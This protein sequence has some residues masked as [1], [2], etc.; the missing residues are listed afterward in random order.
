MPI[1]ASYAARI[2][3]GLKTPWVRTVLILWVAQVVSEIGFGFALPFTPLF[4]QE[5][6]VTDVKQAGLWAGFAAA[7]FAVAVGV[8]SPIWGTLA[9]RYGYRLMIQRAFFGAGAAL[10]AIYFVETPEQMIVLRILHGALTGVFTGIATMVSLTTPQHHLG[11]VLGLMQSALFLGIALGPLIGGAFADAFGLRAGFA[12]TGIILMVT[13]VLVAFVVR[14]PK[15]ADADDPAAAGSP[16]T[17]EDRRRV[18]QQI[19]LVIGLMAIIRLANVAPNPILPLFVQQLADSQERLATTV[20]LMLAATGIAS[21]LSAIVVGRLADR[22]GRRAALLGC[23]VL[24]ALLCPLHALVGTV[25]QLIALRTVFGLAQGGM[26][27]ALQAL[28]VD[29]TPP[30]RRGAAFGLIT[31]ASSVGNG[32]GPVGGSSVAAAFGVQ[33][34]FLAMTPLY[35]IA[36]WVLTRVRVHPAAPAAPAAI[37]EAVGTVGTGGKAAGGTA[38]VTDAAARSSP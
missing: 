38:H 6:G 3:T 32:A 7:S 26:A 30:A 21:T 24:A 36:A 16:Q 33:A 29:V 8:M 37:H 9:D 19:F 1:I 27:T 10:G 35:A 20:G 13:G 28:L 5:L 4:V 34:V 12:A 11:T 31:T 2:T 15:R 22:L 17:D 23:C 14:E 25:W 18:R